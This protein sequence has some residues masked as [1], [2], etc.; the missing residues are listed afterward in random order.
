MRDEKLMELSRDIAETNLERYMFR[1]IDPNKRA[2]GI[3]RIL[4]RLSA[5]NV[6]KVHGR[7]IDGRAARTELGLKA[8]L[9]AKDNQE[10]KD[11]WNYYLMP[12]TESAIDRRFDRESSEREANARREWP[13]EVQV[14]LDLM[15][16]ADDAKRRQVVAFS[17]R[18]ARVIRQH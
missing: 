4:D 11:P 6:F 16:L 12:E 1:R 17:R 14:A 13:E 2:G 7:M 10:W 15:R 8:R 5:V 9:L 18:R 3:R